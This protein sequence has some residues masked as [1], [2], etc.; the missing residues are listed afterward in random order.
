MVH[1]LIVARQVFFGAVSAFLI[2][3]GIVYATAPDLLPFHAQA[4]PPEA[5]EAVRPIYFALM[6]LVGGAS[7]A[8]G[9]LGAYIIFGVLPHRTPWAA[10]WLSAANILA[11]ATAGY[12]AIKLNADTGAD[13]A[14]YNMAILSALTLMGLL[15]H[16]L[17][18]R[19]AGATR[20]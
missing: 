20:S 5:R 14:W 6:K 9:V 7:A 2:W 16:T 17:A 15:C 8:L 18:Q 12:T 13:V 4:V 11:F 10:T 19:S 1:S 3:F